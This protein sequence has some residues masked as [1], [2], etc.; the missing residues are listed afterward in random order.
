[1][2]TKLQFENETLVLPFFSL[3]EKEEAKQCQNQEYLG[4]R[5][6]LGNVANKKNNTM[7]I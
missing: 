3:I 1:M 4:K 7:K 6:M 2:I 5:Q